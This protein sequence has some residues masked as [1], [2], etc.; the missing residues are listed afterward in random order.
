MMCASSEH[1]DDIGQAIVLLLCPRS[2]PIRSRTEICTC[3]RD[4]AHAIN[5]LS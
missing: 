1:T 4:A 5:H 2:S 3:A